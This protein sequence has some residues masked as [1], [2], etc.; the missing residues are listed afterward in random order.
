VFESLT[1]PVAGVGYA[2]TVL[3]ALAW[4][5]VRG[6]PRFF[7]FSFCFVSLAVLVFIRW[8]I[9]QYNAPLNPDEGQMIAN[10]MNYARDFLPFRSVD[11][12][13]SGPLNSM[14]LM[15]PYAFG[16]A[17][18]F[19]SI[20]ITGLALLAGAW[21]FVFAA[22]SRTSQLGRFGASGGL[23]LF[24]ISAGNPDYN[25]YSSE[26]L[27]IFLICFSFFV[28]LRLDANGRTS[29]A[30][31]FAAGAAL[32]AIPFCKM[33]GTPVAVVAG[34]YLLL[35]ILLRSEGPRIIRVATLVI[36]CMLPS[37]LL[38][39]PLALVGELHQFWDW[40]LD[41]TVVFGAERMARIPLRINFLTADPYFSPYFYGFIALSFVGLITLCGRLGPRKIAVLAA[42]S[43]LATACFAIVASR[44]VFSH[45]LLW[46]VPPR[47]HSWSALG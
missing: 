20:R 42:G 40:F 13:T 30:L 10:A 26:Q 22:L 41:W 23:M 14:V 12:T 31:L 9:I 2:L 17:V 4:I 38:L 18:T 46:L 27:S 24:L 25:A 19:V 16:G 39:V 7:N 32:G 34:V 8:P 29:D 1:T 44:L 11:S 5:Y 36:G 37:I 35:L 45:Y 33:Q 15:W 21:L 28:V 3:A 43:W 47:H 6:V